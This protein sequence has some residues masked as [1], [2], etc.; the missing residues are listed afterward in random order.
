MKK[1]TKKIIFSVVTLVILATVT[2]GVIVYKKQE[3]SNV[4]A[5]NIAM[6]DENNSKYFLQRAE[7]DI[8]FDI[9]VPSDA[10]V[11]KIT[12]TDLDGN[13]VKVTLKNNRNGTYSIAPPN[14]GYTE[15]ERYTIIL[16]EQCFFIDEDLKDAR[17]LVF[18]IQREEAAHYEY[19][20]EVKEI[21]E[22]LI[23]TRDN[24]L[25]ISGLDVKEG[26]I[27]FGQ[28]E[29]GDHVIYR[30]DEVYL[31][32]TA[33]VSLP[34]LD[35]IYSELDVYGSSSWDLDTIVTNPDLEIE[36]VENVRSS[37]FFDSL[38][39]TAYASEVV[40]EFKINNAG[41]EA[42]LTK[43]DDNTLGVEIKITLEPGKDGLFGLSQL[44]K[45][46]VILIINP[47]IKLNWF[48]DINGVRY[49]D[50]SAELITTYN[51][52]LEISRQIGKKVDEEKFWDLLDG[53]AYG[54]N[55]YKIAQELVQVVNDKAKGEIPLF[56]LEIPVP[57]VPA[58]SF[59]I[60][61]GLFVEA[62]MTADAI[63]GQSST[64][65]C[66]TGAC[67]VKGSFDSYFNCNKVDG[68]STFTLRG[69]FQTKGG[70]QLKIGVTL[71]ND[72]IASI[73]IVPRFGGYSNIF[74]ALPITSEEAAGK[75]LTK[76]HGYVE[77]GVFV[78]AE[79][80]GKVNIFGKIVDHTKTILPKEF[81]LELWGNDKIPLQ[82]LPTSSVSGKVSD[83]KVKVPKYVITIYSMKESTTEQINLSYKDVEYY[84]SDGEQIQV[85]SSGFVTLP[86]D[87]AEPYIMIKYTDQDSGSMISTEFPIVLEEK[88]DEE[89]NKKN[90]TEGNDNASTSEINEYGYV[91]GFVTEYGEILPLT[92]VTVEVFE[93]KNGILQDAEPVATDTTNTLGFFSMKLKA[94]A[95]KLIVSKEGYQ[96]LKTNQVIK[97]GETKFTERILLLKENSP[98]VEDFLTENDTGISQTGDKNEPT[99]GTA[100]G[101][102][103]D[104]TDGEGVGD[105]TIKIREDWNSTEGDYYEEFETTTDSEGGYTID[106][107]PNGYYT[108]ESSQ[109]GF[110]PDHTNII[111]TD[112]NPKNDFDFTITPEF[113]EGDIRIVLTWDKKPYDLDAY[114]VGTTDSAPFSVC[115]N[116]KKFEEEGIVKVALDVDDKTSY[117]PETITILDDI[118]GTYT[119]YVQNFTNRYATSSTALSLSDAR[120]RIYG[121]NDL[122]TEY[123]VPSDVVGIYWT[124]FQ[125]D[126]NG[127]ITSINKVSNLL[128]ETIQ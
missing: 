71:I 66:K 49:W 86:K 12:I 81:P 114:L 63:L 70:A 103:K 22:T 91:K 29:N 54:E 117:G 36:I 60:D 125:I 6:F 68:K 128:E 2:I 89:S 35:E 42:K 61:V 65:I 44:K 116:N 45:H 18:S 108:V 79:I 37:I 73:D 84:F 10:A 16:P 5:T 118:V 48:Y 56:A 24:I 99:T 90:K 13:T 124:V 47:Q 126:E 14:K 95:Y 38:L 25:D 93:Y 110:I 33:A 122:I 72:K 112:D 51:W 62:E 113:D 11:E 115:F 80:K 109:E 23:S 105:V 107:V 31:D 34:G 83:N 57:N 92:N 85:N 78:E 96:T 82:L 21:Q 119:Y 94:G 1:R 41:V 77:A 88:N 69:R 4:N 20:D 52:R 39:R 121:G 27:V 55:V 123:Y 17:T 74:I 43:E 76:L 32:D 87:Y 19:A 106:G 120:V 40:D 75:N 111:V 104:A 28:D 7:K 50:F 100:S 3:T 26:E 102:I 67:L 64:L 53:T 8:V 98:S 58:L 127:I 9:G 46:K 97:A 15:G 101:T 30:I 59:D